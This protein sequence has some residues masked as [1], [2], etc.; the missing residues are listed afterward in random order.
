MRSRG[1]VQYTR[2]EIMVIAVLMILI[3]LLSGC[4]GSELD[5]TSDNISIPN[6]IKSDNISITSNT[7]I[8]TTYQNI[9]DAFDN[10]KPKDL[11]YYLLE[12]NCEKTE[13][14][15]DIN[16][17]FSV[18]PDLS[19][20]DGYI[21]DYVYFFNWEKGYPIIYVRQKNQQPYKNV[22]EYYEYYKYLNNN[23]KLENTY[24]FVTWI[25][26]QESGVFE[27]KI[28]INGTK[29]GFFEYA[30]LQ[31]TGADF[32]KTENNNWLDK[33]IIIC[34][35]DK[36]SEKL[37]L[38]SSWWPPDLIQKARSLEYQPLVE[39]QK[40]RVDVSLIYFEV[41][42]RVFK[43]KFTFKREYPHT[44]IYFNTQEIPL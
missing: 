24:D 39:F 41:Y 38:S 12:Y 14:E 10:I 4:S 19:M 28:R 36:I 3:Q 33:K 11:P 16:S 1:A 25:M 34:Y 31:L 8:D 6:Y 42:G 35:P 29:E 2:L 44:I 26:D 21:L 5:E 17:Y 7:K 40:D 13:E 9:V 18:L 20:D 43:A 37:D 15:F 22:K 23:N 32:F 27:N 30:V